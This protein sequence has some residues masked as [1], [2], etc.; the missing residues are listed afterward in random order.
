M[1]Y[2]GVPTMVA[3]AQ[4]GFSVTGLDIN[5]N[6]VEE[7]NA[8]RSYIGDIGDETLRPLVESHR[9]S[10]TTDYAVLRSL[11]VV[12]VSVPTPINKYKEPDLSP[13]E[14]TIDGLAK[15]M[16]PGLLVVLQSTTFPGTT[17]EFVLP[18][19]ERAG[20]TAGTDFHLAFASERID[21]GNKGF[22]VQDV[23]KVVGGVTDECS[24]VAA[25]F[26]S[27]FV[28]RVITVGSPK[29]AEMTKLLENTFRSVNIA[30]VNELAMLCRRMEIDIWEVIEAASSKP[31]GFMPFYPGPGVGGHCIPVDPFYLSWKAKEYDFYV[32]FIQLAAETNDNM[33]YYTLS[34]IGEI[35]S[36]HGLAL[37]GARILA[38]GVAFKE[39]V[40]DT[41]NSAA[42]RVMELLEE[43]GANVSYID[44]N[45]PA[46]DL[47]GKTKKSLSMEPGLIEGFDGVV[48]LVNHSDCELERIVDGARLVIDTRNATNSLGIKP[49]VVML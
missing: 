21:P 40:S 2:V 29:V 27:T 7:I 47:N 10:A 44:S 46:V 33:P 16:A 13:M 42:L 43:R 9:I 11:D 25:A 39:N 45:V 4:V 48:I 28:K 30:L 23:P 49:N 5:E 32:N 19:L 31:Y 17:E 36:D 3:A 34:R 24:K 22:L 26:L 41:R 20:F 8:G 12:L 38:L 14:N 1:G 6:R 35:L 18:R 15:N 37:K